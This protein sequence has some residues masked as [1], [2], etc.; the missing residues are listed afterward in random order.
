[1]LMRKL[2]FMQIIKKD[3]SIIFVIFFVTSLFFN[4]IIYNVCE[5]RL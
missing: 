2:K 4:D 5:N 1:M 3:V